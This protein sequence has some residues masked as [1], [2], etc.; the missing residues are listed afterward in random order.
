MN[1]VEILICR[2]SAIVFGADII[3]TANNFGAAETALS[4]A[5]LRKQGYTGPFAGSY[6]ALAGSG[7][8]HVFVDAAPYLKLEGLIC[9]LMGSMQSSLYGLA[10]VLQGKIDKE[11]GAAEA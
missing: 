1:I 9:K 8:Y 6:K 5:A 2:A 4:A 7:R 3:L 11:G 10:Y